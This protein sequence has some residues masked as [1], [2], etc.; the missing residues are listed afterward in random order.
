MHMVSEEDLW[1]W[2]SVLAEA[3]T[4]TDVALAVADAGSDAADASF[5]NLA[6]LDPGSDW[7]RVVHGRSLDQDIADRW[8]EFPLSA[9]T[10]LC[11]AMRTGQPV[12]LG[13]PEVI[14]ERYPNLLADTL[15][16]SLMATASLP[17]HAASG[18][19]LGA[20]GFAWD[21][22]QTFSVDQVSRLDLIARL[23]AQA[24]DRVQV[25]GRDALRESTSSPAATARLVA[26]DDRLTRREIEVL[27]LLAVGYRNTEI[28]DLL[29]VSLRTVE[30]ERSQLRKRLGLR[31]RA[32]LVQF[33]IE[34]GLAPI[35]RTD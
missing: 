32:Q 16:A 10:P 6:L 17:L 23:A 7:I 19:P 3:S 28:A 33:A 13:S 12:L 1:R 14:G 29:G 34:E 27:R 9:Q 31:T 4:P 20:A 25:L 11:E 30:S 26:E 15:A 22:P 21:H 35:T 8:H 5:A 2:M 24:L 18:T